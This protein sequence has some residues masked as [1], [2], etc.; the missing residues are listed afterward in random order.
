[1]ALVGVPLVAQV[2]A[3]AAP[4]S[5]VELWRALGVREPFLRSREAREEPQSLGRFFGREDYPRLEGNPAL[6]FYASGGFH[7]VGKRVAWKGVRAVTPDASKVPDRLWEEA[8]LA[9]ARKRG[10]KEDPKAPIQIKGACVGAVLVPSARE[11]EVGVCLEVQVTSPSGTLLFR[12]AIAQPS[13]Q[14]AVR[15]AIVWPLEC[16]QS[17]DQIETW[18]SRHGSA[19]P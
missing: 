1:M 7:W 17:M 15:R 16:A 4:A 13:I 3:P 10:W 6:G 14:E 2:P 11:P 9:L 8:F 18:R 19:K 12:Y 5:P